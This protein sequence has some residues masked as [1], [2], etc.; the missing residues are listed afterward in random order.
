ME[1]VPWGSVHGHGEE[2]E[3]LPERDDAGVFRVEDAEDVVDDALGI[4]AARK[5]LTKVCVLEGQEEG[6]VG[7]ASIIDQH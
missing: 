3:Q 2:D 5:N 6:G 7:G 1:L 4:D